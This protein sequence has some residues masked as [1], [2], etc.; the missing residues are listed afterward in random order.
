MKNYGMVMRM[1]Y[2]FDHADKLIAK[3]FSH[4]IGKYV[5]THCVDKY[6]NNGPIK[7]DVSI[8]LSDGKELRVIK[9]IQM[10]FNNAKTWCDGEAQFSIDII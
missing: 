3:Q 4:K 8:D 1:T 10:E 9:Y 5:D 7:I 2:L 6:C